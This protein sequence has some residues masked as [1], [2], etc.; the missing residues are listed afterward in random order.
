MHALPAPITFLTGTGA[1]QLGRGG[2][3]KAGEDGL[4]REREALPGGPTRPGG[5]PP[6]RPPLPTPAGAC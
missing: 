3:G 1:G 5:P 2:V 6:L 4:H